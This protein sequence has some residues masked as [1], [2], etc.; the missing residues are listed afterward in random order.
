MGKEKVKQHVVPQSY[1]KRFAKKIP[2]GKG[3]RIGVRQLN[4]N[5]VF[6]KSV[7]EVAIEKNY[8]DVSN[9]GDTKF[10]ENF[11]STEI[12]P[13]YGNEMTNI[14][15]TIMLSRKKVNVLTNAQIEALAKLIAFQILRVPE[16]LEARFEGGK[17]IYDDVIEQITSI[18]G[19]LNKNYLN[20]I[21]E[22]NS[23]KAQII[24]DLTIG[25]IGEL[26]RLERLASYLISNTW[27]FYINNSEIPFMTSD[28]P[29]IMYNLE[30]KSLDY[31][32]NGIGRN[33][34]FIYYPLTSKILLHIIPR[35]FMFGTIAKENNSIHPLSNREIKFI[36][37]V[38]NFQMRH[39][40]KQVFIHP[41]NI[42]LLKKVALP[43]SKKQKRKK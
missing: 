30:N 35:D 3:Y 4:S 18:I 11:F 1:L 40:N 22:L 28:S 41:D 21:S 27:F 29:V 6:L 14:I 9:M 26:E 33:E 39:A 20:V 17:E 38:N 10:W 2:T 34:T 15:S 36:N 7:R 8:Y 12:E 32:Q 19:S 31:S 16:F 5:N 24:R 23:N 13:Q 42:D 43:F 25:S 37:S